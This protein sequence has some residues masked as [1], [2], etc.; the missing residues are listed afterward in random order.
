MVDLN[1]HL[2][3]VEAIV[4]T[5]GLLL[6]LLIGWRADPRILVVLKI[7]VAHASILLLL[8]TVFEF[9]LVWL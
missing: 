6:E 3:Q 2:L 1:V 5:F 4:L 8:H 7:S 9:D